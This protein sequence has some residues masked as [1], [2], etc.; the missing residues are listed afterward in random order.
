MPIMAYYTP[1]P[2]TA[3]WEE[4]LASSRYDLA[5]DPIY[6]NNAIL[7]CQKEPFAW[8]TLKGLKKLILE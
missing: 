4:A 6:T 7:P 3:L 1:I 8:E 2:H 5:L